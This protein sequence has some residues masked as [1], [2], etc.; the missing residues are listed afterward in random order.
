VSRHSGNTRASLNSLICRAPA[1]GP[2]RNVPCCDTTCIPLAARGTV[3][4]R[5]LRV[6]LDRLEAR[7]CGETAS[8]HPRNSGR[9]QA[10][11]SGQRASQ[12]TSLA[13]QRLRRPCAHRAIPLTRSL[14]H[15]RMGAKRGRRRFCRGSTA[16]YLPRCRIMMS[17]VG[18]ISLMWIK[19]RALAV[20]GIGRDGDLHPF[21][22]RSR[23]PS[24]AAAP[25]MTTSLNAFFKTRKSAKR[26]EISPFA[27]F[28]NVRG[29]SGYPPKLSKQTFCPI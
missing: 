1:R 18:V 15:V 9:D 17:A 16:L 19:S 12:M 11:S 10:L 21:A 28:P 24:L 22:A 6:R 4:G 26:L 29:W 25:T 13:G 2:A 8:S 3:K 5:R 23:R 27:G 20:E 7:P 14:H